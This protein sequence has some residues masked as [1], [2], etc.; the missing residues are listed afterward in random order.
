MGTGQALFAPTIPLTWFP[1]EIL[2][3]LCSRHHVLSSSHLASSTCKILFGHPRQGLAHD[4]PS[5]IGKFVSRSHGQLGSAR[6]IVLGRTVLPFYL[7]L[8]SPQLATDAVELLG[9]PSIGS[10]KFRLGLLTSRF[11][12]NHPLKAC[13]VCMQRDKAI[14]AT[15]YWHRAHQ[16]PGV[17]ICPE[18]R[19]ILCTS[20][21]KTT[22]VARFQWLLPS[23]NQLAPQADSSFDIA[24]LENM[25]IAV[26]DFATLTQG[27]RFE[28]DRIAQVCRTE[29]RN[30]D[31]L[32]GIECNRLRR[33]DVGCQ[34]SQHVAPLRQIFE[35]RALP[36]TDEEAASEISRLVYEPRSGLHPLRFLS[37]ITWLFGDLAVFIGRYCEDVLS[38]LQSQR[39]ST[40]TADGERFQNSDL[41]Q[42]FHSLLAAGSSISGASREIGIDP[43]TGMAW[44]TSVGLTT[45]K[46]PSQ[47]KGNLREKMIRELRRGVEK[48]TVAQIGQVSIASVTRLLRTEIGLQDAWREARFSNARCTARRRWLRIVTG[49]PSLGIK[50]AR[51]LEPAAYMWLYRNDRTW[52]DKQ[53]ESF[54]HDLRSYGLRINWDAR[55]ELLAK[56]VADIGLDLAR[57]FPRKRTKLWQICQRLPTLKAKLDRLDQLPLTRRAI[58]LITQQKAPVLDS[59]T[60]LDFGR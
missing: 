31:L 44:A 54:A 19:T 21:F 57:E 5:R 42:S 29:L 53:K 48:V 15:P 38:P 18:H 46:R 58:G 28:A 25:A 11:G 23:I 37:A 20:I 6:E 22:G 56:E 55:D 34:Y 49:N 8:V 12:A 47:M 16:L 3:S 51:L 13:P 40:A 59:G 7:P 24:A 60:A 9:G 35:L 50:A 43:V 33:R 36:G 1:D 4:F 26:I 27:Q 14:F 45:R 30:R 2:F 32:Y 41:K 10:L 17:W 39:F 52:L